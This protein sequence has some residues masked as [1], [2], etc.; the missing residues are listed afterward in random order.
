MNTYVSLAC[1]TVEDDLQPAG[2]SL[3][4]QPAQALD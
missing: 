4:L 1:A 2:Y 3:L